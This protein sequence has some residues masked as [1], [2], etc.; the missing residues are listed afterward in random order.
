MV[1]LFLSD[2]K[3]AF[4]NLLTDHLSHSSSPSLAPPVNV[5][6]PGA[7]HGVPAETVNVF[8]QGATPPRLSE[9]PTPSA[10]RSTALFQPPKRRRWCFLAFRFSSE[11]LPGFWRS[12]P[13]SLTALIK[14]KHEYPP[15]N[16][17]QFSCRKMSQTLLQTQ[18]AR[19]SL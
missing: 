15:K 4:Q 12:G 1:Q 17:Q 10:M 11:H 13:N 5:Y 7:G 19:K 14:P 9:Q 2:S 3:M 16:R 6:S 18:T 8:A